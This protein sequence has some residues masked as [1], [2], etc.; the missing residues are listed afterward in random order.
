V[1]ACPDHVIV[2]G[3]LLENKPHRLHVFGRVTPVPSSIQIAEVEVGLQSCFDV[4]RRPR[5][6]TRDEGLAAPRRLM[7]EQDSAARA[8]SIGFSIIYCS[9]M[10]EEL[11]TGVGAARM[12]RGGFGLRWRRGSEHF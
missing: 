6:F 4:G 8:H 7:V 9:G 10:G 5:Y 1:L 2:R 3:V 12:K 11:G